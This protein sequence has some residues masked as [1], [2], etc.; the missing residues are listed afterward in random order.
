MPVPGP[1]GGLLSPW[2][3]VLLHLHLLLQTST[4]VESSCQ[5]HAD[6][7]LL[8]P[9]HR[10]QPPLTSS[11]CDATRRWAPAALI[12]QLATTHHQKKRVTN[13]SEPGGGGVCGC[14][15]CGC[16][17]VWVCVEEGVRGVCVW[18]VV[19][20]GWCQFV[21]TAKML[22]ISTRSTS[23]VF[24]GANNCSEGCA[25]TESSYTPSSASTFAS[26][27]KFRSSLHAINGLPLDRLALAP[28]DGATSFQRPQKASKRSLG[29]R[30]RIHAG[31]SERIPERMCTWAGTERSTA[32]VVTR[33][34]KRTSV[35]KRALVRA[36][37][38][39]RRSTE[40][41]GPAECRYHIA[42][43]RARRGV[44]VEIASGHQSFGR[45]GTGTRDSE[46]TFAGLLSSELAHT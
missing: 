34:C 39:E 29:R 41:A 15:M 42:S 37:T 10:A 33:A 36:H 31:A 4:V 2:G 13:M 7:L 20:G 21:F 26:A 14:V 5:G 1:G 6:G 3:A 30:I 40:R 32:V 28:I 8:V 25:H 12:H 35:C 23:F 24:V 27:S 43:T 38:K 46:W 16:V 22:K 19:C 17:G 18:C 45:D 9:K 11:P 44:A